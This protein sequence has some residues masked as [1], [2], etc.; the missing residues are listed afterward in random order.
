MTKQRPPLSIDAALARIAGQVPGSWDA[1][2]EE[3][4][5]TARAVR[6]WGDPDTREQI[7]MDAAIKLDLLHMRSGG[8]GAPIFEVYALLVETAQVERFSSQAEL[9]RRLKDALKEGAEAH[10]ALVDATLPGADAQDRNRAAREV[11]E[12]ITAFKAT[13]PSLIPGM[14]SADGEAT[15][16]PQG[17]KV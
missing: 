12:A 14:G 9:A 7:R 11:E 13:L 1:M 10:V 5:L 4:G 8:E 6:N 3:V 16:Q 2:A 15:S 17:G